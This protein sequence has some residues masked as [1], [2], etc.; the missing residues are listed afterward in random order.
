MGKELRHY[1]TTPNH[2]METPLVINR[3][4]IDTVSAAMVMM[5]QT[6]Y[7]TMIVTV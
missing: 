2:K 3:L 6:K 7:C 4:Y 5:C 1:I